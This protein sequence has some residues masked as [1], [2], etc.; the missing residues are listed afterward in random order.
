MNLE[1][2]TIRAREALGRAQQVAMDNGQQAIEGV[3]LL[4][5]LLEDAEGVVPAVIKKLG[6]S[7]D[8]VRGETE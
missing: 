1:K 3:H 2:L 6:A 5:A 4:K 8:A 7:F